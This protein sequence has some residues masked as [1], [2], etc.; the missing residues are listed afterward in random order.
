MN[1]THQ[2]DV[3]CSIEAEVA[4]LTLR[5]TGE[6]NSIT[7]TMWHALTD[8]IHRLGQDDAVRMIVL[9]GDG[10]TFS[11]G[12]DLRDLVAAADSHRAATAFCNRVVDAL[13]AIVSSP[14]LTVA[15]LAQHVTGAG[16]EIAIACDVRLAQQDVTFQIPVAKLGIVADRITIKRLL[17]LAGPGVARQILLLARSV[18]APTCLRIGLVDH[19]VPVGGLDAA[20]E[21]VADALRPNADSAIRATKLL[22]L[23]EEGL[24]AMDDTIDAFRQSLLTGEVA[25]R[26]HAVLERRV[27]SR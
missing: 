15:A 16:A 11:S 9:R 26:G 19:L 18:D 3:T 1:Q 5:R 20:I 8:H 24:L 14:K 17:E 22:L 10:E 27:S 4:T 23:E 13:S 7:D 25:G 2:G 12:A 6:F 21:Q